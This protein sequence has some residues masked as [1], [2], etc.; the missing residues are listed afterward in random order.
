MNSE[1][2][3]SDIFDVENDLEIWQ[4]HFDRACSVKVRRLIC[5]FLVRFCVVVEGFLDH[6]STD[7]DGICL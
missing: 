1:A 5:P 6:F 7:F 4:R 3:V 2:K